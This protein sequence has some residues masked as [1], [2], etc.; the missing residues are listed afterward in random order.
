[1]GAGQAK[2]FK[3]SSESSANA[4]NGGPPNA[5][6]RFT[7]GAAKVNKRFFAS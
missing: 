5:K 4:W 2:G 3:Q 1:M 7:L 6:G